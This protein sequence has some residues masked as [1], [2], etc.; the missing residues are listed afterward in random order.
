MG[1]ITDDAWQRLVEVDAWWRA[2]PPAPDDAAE[3]E[4]IDVVPFD[5]MAEMQERQA[6]ALSDVRARPELM[7]RL[8]RAVSET[9]D[10][11]RLALLHDVL[12]GAVLDH[13]T[14]PDGIRLDARVPWNDDTMTTRL[15]VYLSEDA[16]IEPP[17]SSD[18]V[19]PEG[20]DGRELTRIGGIPTTVPGRPAPTDHHFLLQFD[21]RVLTQPHVHEGVVRVRRENPLPRG[22]V[23]QLFHTMRGDSLTTPDEVGGGATL[24][25]LSED[26]LRHRL[27]AAGVNPWPAAAASIWV[28][29]SYGVL[30]G[31][32]EHETAIVDELQAEADQLACSGYLDESFLTQFARNPFAARVAPVSRVFPLPSPGFARTAEEEA[33]LHEQLPLRSVDDAHVLFIEVTPGRSLAPLLGAR[34]RLHVWLRRSDAQARRYEDVVSFVKNPRPGARP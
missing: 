15:C 21:S 29:P 28:L 32:D 25:Y 19:D 6:T 16:P 18:A 34:R 14:D 30:E 13:Q 1:E 7:S 22:G 3:G 9:D 10:P 26:D 31:A 8:R 4:W 12:R 23:L 27:P 11:A 20:D 17:Y 33:C 24:R 2:L 5:V